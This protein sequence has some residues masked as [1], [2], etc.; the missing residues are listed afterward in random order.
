MNTPSRYWANPANS[1]EVLDLEH[2]VGARIDDT[3]THWVLIRSTSGLPTYVPAPDPDS[4]KVV[5][6]D[7][8]KAIEA[9][10]AVKRSGYAKLLEQRGAGRKLHGHKT[11]PLN[12]L[13]DITVCDDPGKGGMNSVYEL[14]LHADNPGRAVV[15]TLRVEFQNGPI[16]DGG[17]GWTNEAA[18][19]MIIDRLRGAQT[20][21]FACRENA[22]AL[23]K[24]EE[25][26]L[27]LG[28]RSRERIGRGVEGRQVS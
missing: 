20:G 18:I 28:A 24:L 8:V 17:N 11:N 1:A 12:H 6:A 9:Y 7:I 16:I 4:A 19:E 22:I 13:I 27:W 3:N 2:V 10:A 5:L 14:T 25:A 23:T 15:K 26:M 21:P